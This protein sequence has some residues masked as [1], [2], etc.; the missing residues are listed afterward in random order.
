LTRREQ[1][2]GGGRAREGVEGERG[3]QAYGTIMMRRHDQGERGGVR[4]V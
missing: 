4:V 3:W 2:G 1:E